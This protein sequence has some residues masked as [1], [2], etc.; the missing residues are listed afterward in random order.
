MFLS[1]D[2]SNSLSGARLQVM[3]GYEAGPTY[4]TIYTKAPLCFFSLSGQ[5]TRNDRLYLPLEISKWIFNAM[6]MQCADSVSYTQDWRHNQLVLV[7]L[8]S[9][10]LVLV[11]LSSRQ[12]PHSL[13]VAQV[14]SVCKHETSYIL[15]IYTR[16]IFC[17]S[18]VC[19]VYSVS[20]KIT[21][22]Y[23][24]TGCM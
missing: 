1:E 3:F 4:E 9:R 22:L 16:P 24:V 7:P 21:V 14:S 8:S 17:L 23:F 13:L 10:Q 15:S 20:I 2:N 11:P 12:L 6:S 18:Y 19:L 5:Q